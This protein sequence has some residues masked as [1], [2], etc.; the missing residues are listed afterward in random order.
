MLPP[1]PREFKDIYVVF[2]LMETDLHQ[3]WPECELAC[4]IEYLLK[5]NLCVFYGF[6]HICGTGFPNPVLAHL[7]VI[8][9]N[10][11]LTPEHHQFFLYQMLRGLKYIHTG[12]T[13]GLGLDEI[14]LLSAPPRFLTM[15][16]HVQP[17]SS[18]GI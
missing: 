6:Q 15:A 2:E 17:K 4:S 1:S 12:K 8:K 5:C 9:A 13:L 16:V 18:T 7:Q 3:V 10:D 11:D 14:F